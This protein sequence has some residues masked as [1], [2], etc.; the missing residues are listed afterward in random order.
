MRKSLF[1]M[2]PCA[3]PPEVIGDDYTQPQPTRRPNIASNGTSDRLPGI[4]MHAVSLEM[5]YFNGECW[6]ARPL[7][8][9]DS[10]F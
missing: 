3:C 5:L 1:A 6:T 8:P 10:P 9:R 4:G 2:A 7:P